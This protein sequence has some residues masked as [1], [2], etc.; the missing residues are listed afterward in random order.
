VT[1]I[2]AFNTQI[3]MLLMMPKA[4]CREAD[5][6]ALV[7]MTAEVVM[8]EDYAVL[9]ATRPRL[10]ASPGEELLV[11]GDLTLAQVRKMT[12]DYGAGQGEL[13]LAALA[14]IRDS[15]IRVIP[16]PGHRAEPQNWVHRTVPLRPRRAD[17]GA[18]PD[19]IP[20]A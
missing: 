9:K 14:A 4:Q 16:C 5:H 2:D 17:H 11:E 18:L 1:P 8:D 6:R 3:F 15:H 13:D 7:K 20:A 10:A 19:V 12:L